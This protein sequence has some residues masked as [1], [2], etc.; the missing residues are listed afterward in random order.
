MPTLESAKAKYARRT[1]NGAAAYNAA[2]GRMASN[3]S[4]GIQRFIG[5]PPA[6]HIVSS[7]QAGIQ[8][9]QYRP[10]D[11]DKWARNYLAKMTG[12]G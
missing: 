2:K 12:A 7:Y 11:P 10:G 8:A 1:A 9:A 4:S 6:A 3:Y 5:A